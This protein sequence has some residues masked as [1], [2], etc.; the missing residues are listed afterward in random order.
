MK[1]KIRCWFT[2]FWTEDAYKKESSLKILFSEY[3]IILDAEHPDYLFYSCFG[4]EHLKYGHCIKIF[5]SGENIIP[6]LNLCDYA[7]ALTDTVCHDRIFRFYLTTIY[8]SD[9]AYLKMDR[10]KLLQ[11]KFCN[12]V[13]SNTK[14]SA[15]YREQ[16]F[17][18]L[19][20]YKRVDSG[21]GFLN[22]IGY[23]VSD[24]LKFQSEYKFSL[25]I[26]NSS[27][28]GYTTEKIYH[29]FLSRSLPV[30]WGNPNVGA[31]Y[32][33]G[34]FVD[35]MS[36]PSLEDAIEE[37]IR[38]DK[39]DEAYLEKVTTPF[40]PYGETFEDFCS[41][42]RKKLLAFYS[43]IFEQS[44][45]DARR[46]TDYGYNKGYV[47][48]RKIGGKAESFYLKLASYYMKIKK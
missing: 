39:D 1:K 28:Y 34:S 25:A 13:Y 5:W 42:E 17:R 41:Q 29:P 23:N 46:K 10:E 37:I 31:Y 24:K 35:V 4:Y 30:Y 38:L 11:R 36:F 45:S 2:D 8:D 44:L 14:W 7:I 20:E 33:T 12:F 22:N 40:W 15:P 27:L 32:N 48:Y 3:D 9:T 16:I 47:K 6:D 21:G 43:H 26:E 19:S 18:K